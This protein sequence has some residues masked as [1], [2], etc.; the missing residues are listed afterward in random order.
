M[1]REPGRLVRES[2]ITDIQGEI[3]LCIL[4]VTVV[5]V[6]NA[7]GFMLVSSVSVGKP[8]KH[9]IMMRTLYIEIQIIGIF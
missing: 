1:E 4:T 8:N 9:V 7:P 5:I 2:P 6:V 3:T